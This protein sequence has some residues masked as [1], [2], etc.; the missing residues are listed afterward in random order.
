[1][2]TFG[3]SVLAFLLPIAFFTALDRG[4]FTDDMSATVG[5]DTGVVSDYMRGEF[6][7]ISRGMAIIL[8]AV[9]APGLLT[10]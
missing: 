3:N 10:I 8:L 5:I 4:I 7:K 9:W 6:L 2:V 1:M